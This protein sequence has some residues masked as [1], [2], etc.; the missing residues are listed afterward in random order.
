MACALVC[1]A[2]CWF[3]NCGLPN[4]G[5]VSID[6]SGRDQ[7]EEIVKEIALRDLLKSVPPE[8][9]CGI[10]YY[11]KNSE[12]YKD[13]TNEFLSRFA[14]LKITLRRASEIQQAAEPPYK[15]FDPVTQR[16]ALLV[17]VIIDSWSHNQVVQ[18]KYFHLGGARG[19]QGYSATLT[20]S[21]GQWKIIERHRLKF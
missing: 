1:C 4:E 8:A 20:P 13:P 6:K 16:P 19:S 12:D 18:V 7:D 5:S 21:N 17:R 14:D 3:V 15:L 10:E 11:D 9:V 2:I